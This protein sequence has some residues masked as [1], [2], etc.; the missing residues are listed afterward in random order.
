MLPVSFS[1]VAPLLSAMVVF[2]LSG[3]LHMHQ[4]MAAFHVVYPSTL[5]F[6]VLQFVLCTVQVAIGY[7]CTDLNH[8]R[9]L[10]E[11]K[12]GGWASVVERGVRGNVECLLTLLC[13]IAS[14]R[15]FWPP[16]LDGEFVQQLHSLLIV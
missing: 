15:W 12:Y 5:V 9:L 11:Q 14:T 16:Y 13:L 2:V 1:A 6:F 3:V 4:S 10:I 7:K 8:K